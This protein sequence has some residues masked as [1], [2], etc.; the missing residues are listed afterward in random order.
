MKVVILGSGTGVPV[1]ERGCAGLYVR[2]GGEHVLLDAGPGTLR[3]LVRLGVTYLDLDRIFLTHFH[4]DHCLDL[5]SILF[6]MRIPRPPRTKPLVIYGP[7][8]LRQLYRRLNTAFGGW[9][10][11]RTYRLAFKELRGHTTLR[12][13]GYTVRTA[14][15][16]HSPGAL[17]YR[18]EHRGR[19][20]AYSGDTDVCEGIVR[21]GRRADLLIL[22]CSMTDE[23]KV[24][25]HLTPSDC[26][27]IAAQAGCR[28]L[29]LTHFYPV[30]KGYDIPGRVRRAFRGRLTLAR[31]LAKFSI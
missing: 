25:G 30:F 23:R 18:L 10:A 21:L 27:R 11:P 3:Q 17:G 29:V 31:D 26:G 7:R 24:A 4:P 28:H 22:E 9:I 14:P 20:V 15:M 13:G 2:I 16:R 1:K 5:V 19:A 12:L 8:G 6:A